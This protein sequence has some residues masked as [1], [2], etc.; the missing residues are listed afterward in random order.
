MNAVLDSLLP[1]ALIM[2]IGFGLTKQGM[3]TQALQQ[4]LNKLAYWVGLPA[5]L[6]YKMAGADLSADKASD[7]FWPVLAGMVACLIAGYAY[8]LLR[9]L[10]GPSL[11]ALVHSSFRGNL[12]FVALP[13]VIFAVSAIDPDQVAAIETK[14]VLAMVP[15]VVLYNLAGV[16]VLVSHADHQPGNPFRYLLRQLATNPLILACLLGWLV[17]LTGIELPRM[18]IRTCSALGNAAFPMALMGIGSQ[19]ARLDIRSPL[20]AGLAPALIKVGLAPAVGY[21]VLRLLEVPELESRAALIM[22]SAPTAVMS[23]VLTDQLGG[24]SDL[25]AS[26][27]AVSTVLSLITFAI[28]IACPL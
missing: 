18:I 7:I 6:F 23:Y 16:I 11:A 17:S 19:L 2:A 8:G 21:L 1:V 4:G 9:K 24:D 5:L 3:I 25:S 13:I 26:S 22:L 10:P 15:M 12:A 28:V 27:I 20:R 14:V